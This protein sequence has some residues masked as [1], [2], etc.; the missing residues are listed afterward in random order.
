VTQRKVV[1]I[2]GVVGLVMPCVVLT[3]LSLFGVWRI[4]RV[5]NTDLTHILWPFSAMVT[6]TWHSTVGGI[7]TT[8]A[9]VLLNCLAYIAV[10]LLL[11]FTF[12]QIT[13]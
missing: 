1:L 5:G 12:K 7:M 2:S 6:I 9:A 10:G 3:L 13:D 4:V 8:I 11:R